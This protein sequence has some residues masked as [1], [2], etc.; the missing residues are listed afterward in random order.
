MFFSVA[1]DDNA[2]A[3]GK[4]GSARIP[5]GNLISH[6][7]DCHHGE[8]VLKEYE[9]AGQQLLALRIK[10]GALHTKNKQ[11]TNEQ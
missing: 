6:L 7:N 9:A 8:G 3:V 4:I 2:I 5:R 11:K 10:H 1:A